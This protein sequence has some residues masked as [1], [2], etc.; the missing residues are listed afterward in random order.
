MLER[1]VAV[2]EEV[3]VQNSQGRPMLPA[4]EKNMGIH[5]DLVST[6]GAAPGWGVQLY[7]RSNIK[8][9]AWD[10]LGQPEQ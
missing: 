5:G 10:N 8:Q 9:Q 2:L 7:M 6:E 4:L 3:G 1:R